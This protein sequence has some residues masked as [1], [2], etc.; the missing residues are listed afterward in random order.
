MYVCMCAQF[1]A[2]SNLGS[3]HHCDDGQDPALPE[4]PEP[5]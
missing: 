3:L 4:N 1:K 2:E 5:E